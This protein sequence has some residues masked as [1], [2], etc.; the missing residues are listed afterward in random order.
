M[1]IFSLCFF[2]ITVINRLAGYKE[3]LSTSGSVGDPQDEDNNFGSLGFGGTQP[4]Y[5]SSLSK[6]RSRHKKDDSWPQSKRRM[7][8]DQQTNCFSASPSF[9]VQ[10]LHDIQVEHSEDVFDAGSKLPAVYSSHKQNFSWRSDLFNEKMECLLI[11]ETLS[12]PMFRRQQVEGEIGF[13]EQIKVGETPSASEHE[14]LGQCFLSSLSKQANKDLQGFFVEDYTTS[15]LAANDPREEHEF[16]K[17]FHV[18]DADDLADGDILT[19]TKSALIDSNSLLKEGN[20]VGS[21]GNK[22]LAFDQ[23][24]R[25][26]EGCVLNER[27]DN[28]ELDSSIN[29][30]DFGELNTACTSIQRA[31]ILEQICRTA[32]MCTPLSQ[33][34]STFKPLENEYLSV[35]LP[36]GLLEHTNLTCTLPLGDDA[37]NQLRAT[38]T[39]EADFALRAMLS[40]DCLPYSGARYGWIS[41]NS[42]TPPAGKYCER[43]QSKS[44]SSEKLLGSNPELTCFAIEEDPIVDDEN[45]N[46]DEDDGSIQED[47]GFTEINNCAI[48]EA[49]LRTEKVLPN[50]PASISQIEKFHHISDLHSSNGEVLSS[51]KQRLRNYCSNRKSQ[52]GG[53]ENQLS[54]V[55]SNSIEKVSESLQNRFNKEI[56]SSTSSIKRGSQR[57]SEKVKRN[58]IVSNVTSFIPLVQQKQ[59]AA[60]CKAKR[61]IKVRA[62]EAAEAA[63]R[64]EEKKR[65]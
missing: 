49:L 45:E 64:L 14:K 10:R 53:K 31:S 56:L 32:S 52:N 22:E 29:G 5:T 19:S 4:T 21:P 27:S 1:I 20:P 41:K 11:D 24:L 18:G 3:G 13:E 25:V 28:E 65:K 26:N 34:S 39:D 43:I 6:Y 59:A 54:S 12:S 36:N 57:L 37:G 62:L 58:N 16:Q 9:R 15:Y 42:G 7:I 48:G 44:M 63:K 8:E 50:P 38:S 17:I 33:F 40:S 51:V 35:S 60:V 46:A 2:V 23:N 55:G 47:V 61:D 30:I